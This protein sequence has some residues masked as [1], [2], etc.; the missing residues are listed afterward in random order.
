MGSH[1]LN[2]MVIINQ[3]VFGRQQCF[4]YH[5]HSHCNKIEHN[6]GYDCSCNQRYSSFHY[7]MFLVGGCTYSSTNA[8]IFPIE[9]TTMGNKS[10]SKSCFLNF[11]Q[12]IFEMREMPFLSRDRVFQVNCIS[13]QRHC[14]MGL[15]LL[16]CHGVETNGFLCRDGYHT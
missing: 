12:I 16:R 8:M 10:N 13:M 1:F 9:M 6:E 3:Y 7:M 14:N 5:I 15:A 11:P 2:V 4:H